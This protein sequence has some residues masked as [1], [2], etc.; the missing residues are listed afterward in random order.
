[1]T[2]WAVHLSLVDKRRQLSVDIADSL[3]LLE[4]Q[5]IYEWPMANTLIGSISPSM[6]AGNNLALDVWLSPGENAVGKLKCFQAIFPVSD[7]KTEVT[8]LSSDVKFSGKPRRNSIVYTDQRG[9]PKVIEKHNILQAH[10]PDKDVSFYLNYRANLVYEDQVKSILFCVKSVTMNLADEKT[11]YQYVRRDGH[12]LVLMTNDRYV[13]GPQEI[14]QSDERW[15]YEWQPGLDVSSYSRQEEYDRLILDGFKDEEACGALMSPRET[16]RGKTPR[17]M[18]QVKRVELVQP[19]FRPDGPENVNP[20]ARLFKELPSEL[21]IRLFNFRFTPPRLL[22]LVLKEA[23]FSAAWDRTVACA[24]SGQKGS[25]KERG[26]PKSFRRKKKDQVKD[27]SLYRDLV[28]TLERP[29]AP[30]LVLIVVFGL[31]EENTFELKKLNLHAVDPATTL[32]SVF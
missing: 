21:R 17:P 11:L 28:C 10:T 4:E 24:K 3:P 2:E 20:V 9:K 22:A 12:R 5:T 26:T 16:P 29:M 30:N 31:G 7:I 14:E 27:S 15:V 23:D 8:S 25:V 18:S 32:K 13:G 1:M 19:P 6:S